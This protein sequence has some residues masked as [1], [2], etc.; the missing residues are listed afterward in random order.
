MKS[1]N[2]KAYW[3]NYYFYE[4]VMLN[5]LRESSNILYEI[6]YPETLC[7]EDTFSKPPRYIRAILQAKDQK[8]FDEIIKSIDLFKTAF[9]K[10]LK[11][12]PLPRN[13]PK[14][15]NNVEQINILINEAHTSRKL[16]RDSLF[17]I[18]WEKHQDNSEHRLER[19][20]RLFSSINI[21]SKVTCVKTIGASIEVK[22]N[23]LFSYFGADNIQARRSTGKQYRALIRKFN[24]S[25]GEREKLGIILLETS[26]QEPMIFNSIK[27]AKRPHSLEKSACE[28][29]LN[30][31]I[32]IEIPWKFYIK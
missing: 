30:I 20:S 17:P 16:K 29:K 11:D 31:D 1:D 26:P 28:L 8:N 15:T 6:N 2:E 27:Q 25:G 5:T 7:M 21:E 13:F 4:K 12:K 23:D 24:E 9:L 10:V 32:D 3:R 18:Y 22:S 19:L 14:L